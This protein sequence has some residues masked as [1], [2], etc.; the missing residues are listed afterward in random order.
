MELLSECVQ[1]Q[2]SLIIGP[3][4]MLDI[5][6]MKLFM[7]LLTVQSRRLQA[8]YPGGNIDE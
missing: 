3:I 6:I 8:R 2:V 5:L 1:N 7:Q 4:S